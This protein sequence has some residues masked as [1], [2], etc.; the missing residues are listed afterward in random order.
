MSVL[1]LVVL[2]VGTT[3]STKG[4]AK[5]TKHELPSCDA[6]RKAY[7]KNKLYDVCSKF[8]QP[9]LVISHSCKT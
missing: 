1:L 7:K 5:S 8:R 2:V 3:A 4:P 6:A 9:C